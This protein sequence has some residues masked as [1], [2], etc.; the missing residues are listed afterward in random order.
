MFRRNLDQVD[1]GKQPSL[2]TV[3]R[4][5]GQLCAFKLSPGITVRRAILEHGARCEASSID[6]NWSG[7]GNSSPKAEAIHGVKFKVFSSGHYWLHGF[8][9]TLFDDYGS[10]YA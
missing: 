4:A 1:G 5:P 2:A 8:I 7:F 10:S 3:S 9:R 6:H